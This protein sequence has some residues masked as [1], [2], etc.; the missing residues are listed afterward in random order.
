MKI[1]S[2]QSLVEGADL[3]TLATAI[4]IKHQNLGSRVVAVDT[5]FQRRTPTD[6]IDAGFYHIGDV[7]RLVQYSCTDQPDLLLMPKLAVWG[8]LETSPEIRLANGQMAVRASISAT[9]PDWDW[10]GPNFHW[11]KDHFDV[12]VVDVQA[13]DEKLMDAITFQSHEIHVLV[14]DRVRGATLKDWRTKFANGNGLRSPKVFA[15]AESGVT[16]ADALQP[17]HVGK[18]SSKKRLQTSGRQTL[19]TK[20]APKV[21]TA[22]S[23]CFQDR[24]RFELTVD[25]VLGDRIRSD[26]SAAQA[27]WSSLANIE[28]AHYDGAEASYGLR[29]AGAMVAWIREEGDYLDWYC[30]GPT[31]IVA[32]WIDDALH[33]EGWAW[34][35][36]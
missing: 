8:Y 20:T 28:W 14:Q 36:K 19:A 23:R 10:I 26:S 22:S 32:P 11:L 13:G 1:I 21:Q 5:T 15:V 3:S 25:R 16:V 34:Y 9:I 31:D 35:P 2:V 18:A 27:M 6:L 29:E 33:I 24:K 12:L 30:S 7:R 4:A 17:K